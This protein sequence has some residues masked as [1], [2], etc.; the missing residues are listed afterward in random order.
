MK[1]NADVIALLD[2]FEEK[3][4]SWFVTT[5]LHRRRGIE[6]YVVQ[7][8]E[9]NLDEAIYLEA[10]EGRASGL[11]VYPHFEEDILRLIRVLR[12]KI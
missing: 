4:D 9:N 6:N 2:Y 12:S 8:I 10:N 5:N 11:C 3:Y 7:F 1:K